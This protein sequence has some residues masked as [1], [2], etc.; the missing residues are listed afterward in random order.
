MRDQVHIFNSFFY[1]KLSTKNKCVLLVDKD[2]EAEERT[3]QHRAIS[4]TSQYASGRRRSTSSRSGISSCR[5]MSSAFSLSYQLQSKL[6]MARSLHWYLAI[7]CNPGAALEPVSEARKGI[8]AS[9]KTKNE[10]PV[11][12]SARLSHVPPPGTDEIAASIMESANPPVRSEAPEIATSRFFSSAKQA[13]DDLSQDTAGVKALTGDL[14]SDGDE[15]SG[16]ATNETIDQVATSVGADADMSRQSSSQSE[17]EVAVQRALGDDDAH[18]E[19]D[20]LPAADGGLSVLTAAAPL[21]NDVEMVEAKAAP[22]SAINPKLECAETGEKFWE[23]CAFSFPPLSALVT[24]C[25]DVR[26]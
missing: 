1:K 19:E 15:A 21:N 20:S 5:S 10:Q 24:P 3:G 11:R 2:F 8:L 6:M 25:A 18:N 12:A 22:S 14:G 9:K 4:R 13:I 17:S 26:S 7:I 16:K 23:G